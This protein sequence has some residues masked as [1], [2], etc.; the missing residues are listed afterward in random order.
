MTPLRRKEEVLRKRYRR[1]T[2]IE[3][4]FAVSLL[5]SFG[6]VGVGGLLF[7]F[8]PSQ[9]AEWQGILIGVI[10]TIAGVAGAVAGVRMAFA[11]VNN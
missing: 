8:Q 10:A 2:A 6:T 3:Y 9:W 7:G 4:A 5:A 1:L 11:R